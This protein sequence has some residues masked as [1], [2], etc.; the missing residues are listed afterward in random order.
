MKG[1][2]IKTRANVEPLGIHKTL[3]DR[4]LSIGFWFSNGTLD[5]NGY[6]WN[7]ETAFEHWGWIPPR[8]RIVKSP[9][10]P[11]VSKSEGME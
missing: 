10:K 7:L 3:E 4:L 6:L 9:A 1:Y 5:A 2:K 11:V 8:Q